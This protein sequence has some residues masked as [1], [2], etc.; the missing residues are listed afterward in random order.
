[1]ST[2]IPTLSLLSL[3]LSLK[4]RTD[5]HG[6]CEVE[7]WFGEGLSYTQ[8]GY[9]NLEVHPNSIQQGESFTVSGHRSRKMHHAM[10]P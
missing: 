2:P 7:W 5:E 9:S 3:C 8:F 4:Q 10:R 1:M 6:Q